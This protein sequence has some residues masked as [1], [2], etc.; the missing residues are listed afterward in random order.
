MPLAYQ[1]TVYKTQLQRQF[2]SGGQGYRWLDKVKLQMH[3]ACVAGAPSRSGQLKAS[4]RSFIRGI[5]QWACR[6]EIINTAEHALWVHE[7]TTTPIT[8]ESAAYMLVPVAPGAT[9]RFRAKEVRG[10]RANPW[11]DDACT[12]IGILHGDVAIG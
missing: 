10:Q 6:A 4:H 9:R 12:R 8:P 7:G 2:Q 1:V 3:R 5:N 11:M